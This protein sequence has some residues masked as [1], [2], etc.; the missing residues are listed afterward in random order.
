MKLL[1]FGASGGTGRHVISQALA[2]GLNVAAFVRRTGSLAP[3]RGLQII[4]GNVG[5][6]VAVSN[7]LANRDVV[8]SALGVGTPLKTD[9]IV[10]AGIDHIVRAMEVNAGRRLIYLSFIGVTASRT[11]AGPLI[12]YV[13]RFPLRHEIADH[14]QK[15]GRIQSSTIQWTIVRAPKLTDGPK[16]GAYRVG[17]AITAGSLF[18]RLS[19][20]DVA[21]FLV[22]EALEARFPQTAV[23]L[24]PAAT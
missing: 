19:R 14:E 8:I 11:A 15:E 13:A 2:A 6:A 3:Q 5:D 17:E 22:K 21:D 18:P 7:A 23:R 20:A 16:S 1:V 9:P 24:L 4:E 12:R 10:R